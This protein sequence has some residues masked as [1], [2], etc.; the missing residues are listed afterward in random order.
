MEKVY[1]KPNGN[2]DT[3]TADHIPTYEEFC[4]ANDSH[5]DD[6]SSI[7]SRIGLE[8]IRRG[9]KHD[10]TKEVLSKMFYH[11][12]VETM[13]GNM[14]FEDGQWAKIHYF[15]SCERHH[16]NRNVPDDVNFIDILEMICDC[17]CAGKAR[18]GKDFIDVRL[19]GDIILKAFYNTVELINEHVEL[20]DVSESNPGILKEENN[21]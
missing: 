17:V 8:L 2:G 4:I 16:L 20:E 10:I 3:R 15:N 12:M 7:I 11:D 21:G 14:K 6:V 19:N 1:I 5:R 13:E 9:N 18:S